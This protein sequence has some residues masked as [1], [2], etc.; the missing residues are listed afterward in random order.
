MPKDLIT[1]KCIVDELS[2]TLTQARLDKISQPEK[3]EIL[4]SLRK[5][6]TNYL[7]VISSNPN[8][9]R[10]HLSKFKKPNPYQAPSFNMLLRKH[11]NNAVISDFRI[12]NNDRI[13]C[14]NFNAKDELLVPKEMSLIVELLGRYSNIILLNE[15]NKIIDAIK[16]ISPES[17]SRIILPNATYCLP[18]QNKL[19]ITDYDSIK[20]L[21]IDKDNN[22][23]EKILTQNI[24]GI[25]YLTASELVLRANL[26]TDNYPES[27]INQIKIFYNIYNTS[28]YRPCVAY[29]KDKA[30]DYMITEYKSLCRDFY[31]YDT[32]N[33]ALDNFYYNKDHTERLL[34]ASKSI[35]NIIKN[36]IKRNEKALVYT[37]ERIENAKDKDKI[38]EYGDM[39]LANIHKIRRGMK[40]IEVEN[41]FIGGKSVIPLDITLNPQ[42]NASK[43][44]KKYSKLSRSL[45]ISLKQKE[46]LECNLKYLNS[47]LT[48]IKIAKDIEDIEYI[49]EELIQEKIIRP[50][51]SKKVHK[52]KK[53]EPKFAIIEGFKVYCGSNNLENSYLTLSLARKSDIFVHAK[54]IHGSHVIIVK[55]NKEIPNSVIEKACQLAAYY[56]AA[57][58]ADKVAVDYTECQYV[59][60]HPSNKKGMVI[61]TD[62]S[63]TY[64]KPYDWLTF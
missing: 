48:Q 21:L 52:P 19:S 30:D 12:L 49:R 31:Y 63:T 38:R 29:H 22:E 27:I 33:E 46:E 45:P 6:R 64:V 10:I 59:R 5:D 1:L 15:N 62:Y 9:P 40:Q 50:K 13:I 4:L 23:I 60:K 36:H 44:Y 3:D 8:Y 26:S 56:S 51:S 37:L 34:Q 55:D 43:Y 18:E 61:Y 57:R 14:I 58:E 28:D 35:V 41:Y 47:I 32:L 54:D 16:H 53:R 7:L 39:I 25:S 17:N 42:Q 24:S 2:S 11:L 20:K